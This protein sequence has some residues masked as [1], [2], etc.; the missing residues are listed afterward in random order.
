MNTNDHPVIIPLVKRLDE[1][2]NRLAQNEEAFAALI[3][4]ADMLLDAEEGR[5]D[6]QRQ[7]AEYWKGEC[8]AARAD[9]D[10]LRHR[11]HY[12]DTVRRASAEWLRGREDRRRRAPRRLHRRRCRGRVG[13]SS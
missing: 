4:R 10:P 2:E 13:R 12:A 5:T 6:F 3:Q 9:A 11:L 1:V 8:L 7:R